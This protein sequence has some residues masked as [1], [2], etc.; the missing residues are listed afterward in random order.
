[1]EKA[2]LQSRSNLQKR[3]LTAAPVKGQ[4]QRGDADDTTF[5][6]LGVEANVQSAPKDVTTKVA[7]PKDSVQEF[8]LIKGGFDAQY[9]KKKMLTNDTAMAVSDS[10]AWS[11]IKGAGDTKS[12]GKAKPDIL[13]RDAYIDYTR[14]QIKEF[15]NE[16]RNQIPRARAESIY[17]FLG[18]S[19]L[20]LCLNTLLVKDWKTANR[21][22]NDFL[23]KELSDYTRHQLLQIQAELKK[24]KK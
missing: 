19:Y 16:L 4:T 11:L 2:L 22:V 23:K 1:M 6:P 24:L 8:G 18:N 10:Q 5:S 7:L 20:N 21:R 13:T 9:S 15:E 12:S 17:V 14:K 3:S